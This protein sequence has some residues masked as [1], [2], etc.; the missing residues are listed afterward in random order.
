MAEGRLSPLGF[1]SGIFS[2]C[3]ALSCAQYSFDSSQ[4]DYLSLLSTTGYVLSWEHADISGA[5]W[6]GT[7]G[8]QVVAHMSVQ[9]IGWQKPIRICQARFAWMRHLMHSVYQQRVAQLGARQSK[10]TLAA[11]N[12]VITDQ[13]CGDGNVLIL[14]LSKSISWLRY[15]KNCIN[16]YNCKWIYNYLKIKN[17]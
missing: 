16:S 3:R 1:G 14:T 10:V 12:W 11:S 13:C 5:A 9:V 2:G 8:T 4:D 17:T 7:S 15:W 6:E